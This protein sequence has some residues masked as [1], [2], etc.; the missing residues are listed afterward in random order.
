MTVAENLI[1]KVFKETIGVE[2]EE[3]IRRM[4]Y[5]EAMERFGSDKPDTRFGLEICDITDIVAD[6]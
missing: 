4:T 2:F 3:K 1:R 6:S 5:K